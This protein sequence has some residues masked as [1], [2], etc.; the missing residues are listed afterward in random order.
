[1]AIS[2]KFEGRICPY[3]VSFGF[4]D[5]ESIFFLIYRMKKKSKYQFLTYF[6]KQYNVIKT[7]NG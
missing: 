6:H 5:L 1:M 7:K 3:G 4:S 2:T